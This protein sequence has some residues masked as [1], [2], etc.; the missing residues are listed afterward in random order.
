MVTTRRLRLYAENTEKRFAAENSSRPE[1]SRIVLV[2]PPI[3]TCA[4]FAPIRSSQPLGIWQLGSYLQSR[5]YET[6]IIDSVIEGWENKTHLGGAQFDH[7]AHLIA[8]VKALRAMA[9][10]EFLKRYPVTDANGR[11]S[12]TI[13]RTGLGEDAIV[14]RVRDFNPGWIGISIIATCEHRGAMDLAK[15]LKRE[16][17]DAKIVAGGQH[18][19]DMA[20]AVLRDS[21]GSIDF[22]VK[23]NGELTMEALLEGRDP[24][25]GLAYVK[26]GSLV[27]QPDSPVTPRSMLP[28]YDPL[29]LAH[30]RYP[31]PATHSYGTAGRK[32]TDWMFSFGCHKGCDFC[33]QGKVR[34]GY[35]HLSLVQA[36]KQLRLFREHGYEEIILQDD[37]LLG[38]PRND[39][40]G[41][42]LEVVRLLKRF[43][44]HWHD[45][46]G[47]EFERLDSRVAESILRMNDAAGAGRCTALYVPF[48]PRFIGDNR[49]LERHR[50]HRPK[51]V[52]LLKRLKDNGIYTFT[53]WIW[54]HV[55]Q[56]VAD[57]D[58]NT[59]CYEELL[60][61][62]YIDQ[63]VIFGLSYL[64]RTTDG[65]LY[66]HHIRDADDWEGYSIFVPHAGTDK[67]SFEEVNIAVLEAYRRLNPLQP[68]VEPW[69]YGFPPNVPLEWK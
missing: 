17:P 64:P 65:E 4:A 7:R 2:K 42:F 52:D 54:G 48:N 30:I 11:I 13:I 28:P 33:R 53:S 23:G 46:G 43:G 26:N 66:R 63:A 45:N 55:G 20:E 59:R 31:F 58:A 16:F 34:E 67:A 10:N 15:R 3:Y 60:S 5:G 29:L 21:G 9:P 39:G 36:E 56:S 18:A 69:A 19:T 1:N 44:F 41:L 27:E 32:Y 8:K 51:T 38:G 61:E 24:G 35:R 22:V 47:V 6:R 12:R 50:E 57:M 37:S 14:E 49:A 25:Q 62:G 68:H 40:K